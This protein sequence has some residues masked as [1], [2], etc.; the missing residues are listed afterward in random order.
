MMKL[1]D[2]GWCGGA[3][4]S[5]IGMAVFVCNQISYYRHVFLGVGLTISVVI[6]WMP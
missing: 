4:A 1:I 2:W 6:I 3:E 5:P